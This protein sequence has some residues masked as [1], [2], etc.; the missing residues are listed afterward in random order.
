MEKKKLKYTSNIF[1]TQMQR[2]YIYFFLNVPAPVS[3]LMSA[4]RLLSIIN[5]QHFPRVNFAPPATVA[6]HMAGG[7]ADEAPVTFPPCGPGA[8]MS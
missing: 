3:G 8:A 2:I 5:Q 6:E 1:L 4:P 7:G